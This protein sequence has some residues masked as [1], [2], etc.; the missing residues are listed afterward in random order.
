MTEH[1]RQRF[2]SLPACDGQGRVECD[3]L[4][5]DQVAAL[6]EGARVVVEVH[7]TGYVGHATWHQSPGCLC[8]V[9]HA[10]LPRTYSPSECR[11]WLADGQQSEAAA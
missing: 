8:R 9:T 6:P 11:V 1:E 10:G 7:T 4:T 2:A 3:S 5:P